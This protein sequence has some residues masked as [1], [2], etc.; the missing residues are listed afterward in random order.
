MNNNNSGTSD[1]GF[2][3]L[4]CI[5]VALI[6]AKLFFLF[7]SQ[8]ETTKMRIWNFE[9]NVLAV[10]LYSFVAIGALIAFLAI[11]PF[12]L[13]IIITGLTI[14]IFIPKIIKIKGRVIRTKKKE[15]LAPAYCYSGIE[16][17]PFN[18]NLQSVLLYGKDIPP[19]M[20]TE[21]LAFLHEEKTNEK[22]FVDLP[23]CIFDEVET[24]KSS[25]SKSNIIL[26]F[27]K[28]LFFRIFDHFE[29]ELV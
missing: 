13:L 9:Q 6:G 5:L 28:Y 2:L 18:N 19:R 26:F 22:Y 17:D 29:L 12:F 14:S 21:H 24:R 27:R 3:I 23:E 11:F 7:I 1:S 20:V 25:G 8:N 10:I 16:S 4:G 15:V